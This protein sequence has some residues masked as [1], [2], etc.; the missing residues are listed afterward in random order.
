M[1]HPNLADLLAA[2]PNAP[3]DDLLLERIISGAPLDKESCGDTRGAGIEVDLWWLLPKSGAERERLREYPRDL[4]DQIS[5]RRMSLREA[6]S[7]AKPD[8]SLLTSKM[9]PF[10]SFSASRH[11]KSSHLFRVKG[12]HRVLPNVFMS[13][14]LGIFSWHLPS[15]SS[16]II[17]M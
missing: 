11:H 3:A 8:G 12:Q 15:G 17:M 1:R 14:G 2:E 5:I 7:V 16:A 10:Y 4:R 6:I 13:F 9:E